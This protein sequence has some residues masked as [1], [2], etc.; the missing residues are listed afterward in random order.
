M[1]KEYSKASLHKLM[2]SAVKSVGASIET[3]IAATKAASGKIPTMP[4]GERI[5]H[6]LKEF[7]PTEIP[8]EHSLSVQGPGDY[9]QTPVNEFDLT[10][11]TLN[12]LRTA[13]V[14]VVA[15]LVNLTE[16]EIR[17]YRHIGNKTVDEIRDK[18]LS[19]K[20]LD[21][22]AEQHTE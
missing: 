22:K 21:F 11:R 6:F 12:C 4:Y 10:T 7:Q 9:F 19:P 3:Y 14:N 2:N 5:N 18:I 13:K 20:S 15:D 1:A 16:P 8:V 17:D